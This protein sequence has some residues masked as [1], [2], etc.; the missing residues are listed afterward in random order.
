[1]TE[2]TVG[3]KLA[4]S[5]RQARQGTRPAQQTAVAESA[6]A[7]RAAA[8]ALRQSEQAPADSLSQPWRNLHPQ[9]I[10]PD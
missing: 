7:P 10:W 5:V 9:R 1:M 2:K 8:T 6:R 4:A 3:D